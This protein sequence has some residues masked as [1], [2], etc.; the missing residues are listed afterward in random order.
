LMVPFWPEVA[1]SQS[2]TKHRTNLLK[3]LTPST[4]LFFHDH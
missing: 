4:K 3:H 1:K 2:M